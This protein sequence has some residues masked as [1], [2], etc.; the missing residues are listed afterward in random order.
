MSIIVEDLAQ[1]IGSI[2]KGD[3]LCY[4]FK[5]Y[6]LENFG[7]ELCIMGRTKLL[8]HG[9]VDFSSPKM[10]L[11]LLSIVTNEPPQ[12]WTR[13]ILN[14]LIPT[15]G[16][17]D[18]C[19][20]YGLLCLDDDVAKIE[21]NGVKGYAGF[22]VYQTRRSIAKLCVKFYLWRALL[23]DDIKTMERHCAA[24]AVIRDHYDNTD[25]F[26]AAIKMMLSYLTGSMPM[27]RVDLE[28]QSPRLKYEFH[29][30]LEACNYQ[31]MLLMAQGKTE[32]KHIRICRSCGDWFFVDKYHK[33]YC[34]K[35]DCNPGK[36]YDDHK[37]TPR[38]KNGRNNDGK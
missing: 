37:R 2:E 1:D 35:I 31:L 8:S 10:L 14:E 13:D 11:D 30:L 23:E 22:K 36:F 16:M 32:A 26:I 19:Q 7:N 6:R 15:V 4:R 18:W 27:I 38:I 24:I 12:V 9:Y 17:I 28:A 34:P 29:S 33:T 25:D 3:A 20:K 21:V 5:E